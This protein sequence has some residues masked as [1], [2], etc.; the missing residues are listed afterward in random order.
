M[1]K[2]LGF[3]VRDLMIIAAVPLL[4]LTIVGSFRCILLFALVVIV[5]EIARPMLIVF[6]SLLLVYNCDLTLFM[7]ILI[8]VRRIRESRSYFLMLMIFHELI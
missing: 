3:S 6:C 1:P 2:L 7:S 8:H 5:L 4:S